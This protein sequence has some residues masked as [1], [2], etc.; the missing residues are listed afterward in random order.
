MNF[1]KGFYKGPILKQEIALDKREI[2]P[3]EIDDW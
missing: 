3:K 1:D 2:R